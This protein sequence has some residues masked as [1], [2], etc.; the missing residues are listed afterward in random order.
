MKKYITLLILLFNL[1]FNQTG[2]VTPKGESAMGV[3]GGISKGIDCGDSDCKEIFDAGLSYIMENG[4]ELSVSYKTHDDG[5]FDIENTEFYFLYHLKHIGKNL[6]MSS[7]LN[8]NF[9]F[10]LGKLTESKSDNSAYNN[11]TDFTVIGCTLYSKNQDNSDNV[12]EKIS[13]GKIFNLN[14]FYF[15]GSYS[16]E[17]EDG[18][19]SDLIEDLDDGV[20]S[21]GIGVT[22]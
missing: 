8:P 13:F 15:N 2:I 14:S 20:V 16:V 18:K 1:S 4:L 17:I 7:N 10:G 6:N 12:D 21:I 9:A 22:F 11:D 19:F 5:E 3:W